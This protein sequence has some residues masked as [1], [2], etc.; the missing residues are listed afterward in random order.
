M[1]DMYHEGIIG[2]TDVQSPHWRVEE[3]GSWEFADIYGDPKRFGR[4]Y[5]FSAKLGLRLFFGGSFFTIGGFNTNVGDFT[6]KSIAFDLRSNSNT[7]VVGISDGKVMRALNGDSLT[8]TWVASPG[9][10][11]AGD[12]ITGL[13]FVPGGPKIEF[14]PLRSWRT[15]IWAAS[16]S[17][18]LF[19]KGDIN[20]DHAW[21]LRGTSASGGGVIDLAVNAEH[22]GRVYL[23]R[24]GGVEMTPNGG[25]TW[26][27]VNGTGTD[28]LPD[29]GLKSIFAHPSQGSTLLVGA[30]GG[31]YAS[32]D[33][34]QH[35]QR[36]DVGLPN[37]EIKHVFMVGDTLYACTV[38]VVYGDATSAG[39][40]RGFRPWVVAMLLGSRSVADATLRALTPL[41]T[42]SLRRQTVRE[43]T[44]FR[45]F[46]NV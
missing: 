26:L 18:K 35:W 13:A 28:A 32:F 8:P 39:G 24:D 12:P 4:F 21:Q 43:S 31:I 34:G 5:V 20:D 9:I 27:A 7:I 44:L 45:R 19:G 10:D 11:L 42:F 3:G 14:G 29:K 38:G 25:Q 33:E 40:A 17:G 23:L 16:A 46:P 30:V 22:R 36:F 2:T 1:S 15:G 6:P 37:A 41:S